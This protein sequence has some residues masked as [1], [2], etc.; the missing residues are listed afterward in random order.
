MNA[1]ATKALRIA[2]PLALLVVI[3]V[4]FA[5]HTGIGTVS[6]LGWGSISL[7]CPLGALGTML[8]SKMLVPRAVISL[9]VAV[10]AIILLGRA[11]CAW[12]CP[13]PVVSKVRELFRKKDPEG[14]ADA[15][16]VAAVDASADAEPQARTH[17]AGGPLT[18]DELKVIKGACS[19]GEGC[20]S[21]AEKRGKIDSR[22]VILGGSLLTA[23]IF[24]FPVFC[25]VCPIG[26]TFATVL[27]VMLLFSGGDVTWSV[28]L[29]PALLVAE[30]VLFKKWC[31]KICPLSAFMSLIGKA[32]RTFRPAIDD[33]K[34]LET[35]KGARC[36]VCAEVCEQGIDP[37]HP[38]RGADWSECTKCRACAD[39]CPGSAITMSFL[40]R[41]AGDAQEPPASGGTGRDRRSEKREREE[42]PMLD[43]DLPLA[44]SMGLDD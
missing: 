31:S 6:A 43:E 25:L 35:S 7:L 15:K 28:V 5:T 20:A 39:A 18:A 30:V 24:G 34:C 23:A 38:E 37:R 8:A 32:N 12:A 33:S 16:A 27:L 26:L 13:V 21:C 17:T 40:P 1:K 19:A 41:R 3:G 42:P 14:A 29:V 36:G 2:I 44:A 9:V 11:F 4:G 22:H 10:V